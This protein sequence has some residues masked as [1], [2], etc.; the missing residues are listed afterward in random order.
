[1]HM[2]RHTLLDRSP[3][4]IKSPPCTCQE[5]GLVLNSSANA[6][7]IR[8][9]TRKRT[10]TRIFSSTK[11]LPTVLPFHQSDVHLEQTPPLAYRISMTLIAPYLLRLCDAAQQSGVEFG[12]AT[13]FGTQDSIFNVSAAKVIQS[14]VTFSPA[15]ECV[16][17]EFMQQFQKVSAVNS[18]GSLSFISQYSLADGKR[19]EPLL[20]GQ[21]ELNVHQWAQDV[22]KL[23]RPLSP[24]KISE[25]L[26]PVLDLA[27]EY[28]SHLLIAGGFV[29]MRVILLCFHL[30]FN[31]TV[32]N[33][34]GK[35]TPQVT[36]CPTPKI[37]SDLGQIQ[38]LIDKAVIKRDQ[39]AL[40]RLV[41]HRYSS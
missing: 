31:M 29:I 2:V 22:L 25:S 1:M 20:F 24:R 26:K 11:R 3:H 14:I 28:L 18:L 21:S 5:S 38:R 17:I 34:G 7:E 30:S 41:R 32:R 8:E 33:P 10:S 36:A 15:G 13:R 12:L 37:I 35:K 39:P 4:S 16:A 23:L 9:Q 6:N 27:T 40:K 19:V